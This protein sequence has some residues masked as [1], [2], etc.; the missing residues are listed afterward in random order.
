MS[1]GTLKELNGKSAIITGASQGIGAAT[2]IELAKQGV[3][4]VLM[5]RNQ[6]KIESI[7]KEINQNGGKAIAISGDVTK[8]K[9]FE[10]AV[11]ACLENFNTL[12]LL[13]NNAGTINP[14]AK[15]EESDPEA[16]CHAA[17]INYKGVYLGMR[18]AIPH[19]LKQGAG[20]ILN[21]SSGAAV[22][23]L[24]G[25]S[26]YC[27]SKAAALSLTKCG[28]KEFFERGISVVGLS[29]GTVATDMQVNIKKSG[30]NP[31][32]QL[33]PS[34]HISPDWVAKAIAYLC[35]SAGK[36]YSGTDF[37]LKEE[38]NLEKVGAIPK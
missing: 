12:D 1:L 15:L 17:D 9:D 25:W 22:S 18:T 23:A 2:C 24:E 7:A 21:V 8:L 31:V 16:W 6:E 30:I 34:I 20:V 3:S 29:P 32:S 26:H 36:E 19:M 4:V 10:R 28:H 33:D 35:T 5:A 11:S 14:I 38:G 37:A 13:V 27:S